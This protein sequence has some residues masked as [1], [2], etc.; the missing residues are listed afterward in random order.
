MIRFGVIIKSLLIFATGYW[1]N[2]AP[3]NTYAQSLPDHFSQLTVENGLSHSTIYTVYQDRLGFI[4]MGTENGLNAY[5]GYRFIHF[6]HDPRDSTTLPNNNVTSI[7]EDDEARLWL[8]TWGGGLARFDRT[9][10]TFKTYKPIAGLNHT[11]S[12]LRIQ[13][14]LRRSDGKLWIGTN[15]GGVNIFDPV[16]EKFVHVSHDP[17]SEAS[18]PHPRVWS[19]AEQN[20]AVWVGTGNGLCRVSETPDG[21]KTE[22]IEKIYPGLVLSHGTIRALFAD[23]DSLLWVGT[24]DG[25]DRVDLRTA[26]VRR[27]LT[28]ERVNVVTRLQ[29]GHLA[30]GTIQHGMFIMDSDG[31]V[32]KTYHHDPNYAHSLGHNDVRWIMQDRSGIV[33]IATRGEGVSLLD[34][35]PPKFSIVADDIQNN[36]L[37]S[38]RVAAVFEDHSANGKLVLAGTD[39]GLIVYNEKKRSFTTYLEPTEDNTSSVWITSIYK[40]PAGFYWIGTFGE[41]LIW[42][43]LQRGVL[44]KIVSRPGDSTSLND[45][46]VRTIYAQSINGV[47]RLWI[48]TYG[49]LHLW[50]ESNNRFKR[51]VAQNGNPNSLSH[52]F[53]RTIVSDHVNRLWIGTYGGGLNRFEPE[54]NNW[55]HFKGN[56][57]YKNSIS[58]NEIM[59]I[60]LDPDTA[61]PHLWIGTD[62]NGISLMDIRQE[63]FR[64]ISLS[65]GLPSDAVY[66]I[67]PTGSDH[68][69]I[70]TNNGLSQLRY[71]PDNQFAFR[72]FNV[73]DKLPSNIFAQGAYYLSSDGTLYFGGVHGIVSVNTSKL[74]FNQISGKPQ[75]TGYTLHNGEST[76]ERS[77]FG[78]D[79]LTLESSVTWL[80]FQF[81][82]LEYTNSLKNK[83]AYKLDGLEDHWI[84]SDERRSASYNTLAPGDYTFLIKASNNDGVWSESPTRLILHVLPPFWKTWYFRLAIVVLI[85][86][87]LWSF[88]RLRLQRVEQYNR[89]LEKIINE[90]TTELKLKNEELEVLNQKKN[91]F[92]GIAAHDLRNPLTTIIGYVQLMIND[93]RHGHATM[94]DVEN[95]LD[96][97]HKVSQQMASLVSTLLDWSSIE[98]GKVNLEK[99]SESLQ[100]IIDECEN[101]HRRAAEQKNIRLAV[102]RPLLMPNVFVDRNRIL[103]VMDNLLSNAIKYTHPGGAV[104]VFCEPTDR[105]ICVHVEDTGQGLSQEDLNKVFKSYQKLS[106]RPTAGEVSTG[107]GLAI[108]KKVIEL[109]GG[110]VWVTSEKGKGSRFSFSVPRYTEYN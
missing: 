6:K 31:T 39:R 90:R 75:I 14:I 110:R 92:L 63:T 80:T 25:L 108:V 51:W 32:I 76:I 74:I 73:V 23:G 100:R 58:G 66:N 45:N 53:I 81:S 48:G 42:F 56:P 34:S 52:N 4:W 106:A 69:W 35:K 87:A 60:A 9:T 72:N 61:H 94:K 97:V 57:T 104:R 13:Y 49:G 68:F 64:S 5:D 71:I 22:R 95:D 98:A 59:T 33:W 105:E 21:L 102:E 107:L 8:G 20:H 28:H 47:R 43:D 78:L 12:D 18:L 91:E 67:I 85:T 26:S 27:S 93:I 86:L 99:H 96:T 79:E 62:G 15:S 11:L 84:Y 29:N 16:T 10:S 88:H 65:D 46:R 7:V 1:L 19:L 40:D 50:D 2:P 41:G 17:H 83:Y 101:L 36:T 103:E 109:H 70:S 30:A 55:K 3:Q 77:T 89:R 44:K 38:T 54:T 82:A 24:Q 37:R